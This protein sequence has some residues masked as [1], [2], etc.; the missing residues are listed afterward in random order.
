MLGIGGKPLNLRRSRESIPFG[1]LHDVC[2]SYNADKRA[3]G[4]SRAH[5]RSNLAFDRDSSVSRSFA[6]PSSP[7]SRAVLRARV[8]PPRRDV[9]AFSTTL[10]RRAS[11]HR[12]RRAHRRHSNISHRFL[13]RTFAMRLNRSDWYFLNV[14]VRF[15]TILCL[16]SGVTMAARET[17]VFTRSHVVSHRSRRANE[18]LFTPRRRRLHHP[19]S[20]PPARPA[21][22]DDTAL[23]RDPNRS[24][25]VRA[26]GT[27]DRRAVRARAPTHRSSPRRAFVPRARIVRA[28]PLLRAR[29]KGGRRPGD[30][31]R[32]ARAASLPRASSHTDTTFFLA[33]RDSREGPSSY[34]MRKSAFKRTNRLNRASNC[35]PATDRFGQNFWPRTRIDAARARGGRARQSARRSARERDGSIDRRDDDRTR[36]GEADRARRTRG[37]TRTKIRRGHRGGIVQIRARDGTGRAR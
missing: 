27:R 12:S 32:G 1:R 25:A 31:R 5:S 14:F 30:A 17:R 22:V 8:C 23:H 34:S 24:R 9:I 2:G 6:T 28:A 35:A 37:R 18:I 4:Q 7:P 15:L 19:R 16:M 21:R 3:F 29:V 33:D 10:A 26:R 36:A 20:R 11:H 13:P